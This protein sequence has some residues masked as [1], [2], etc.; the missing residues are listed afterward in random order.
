METTRIILVRHGETD[1][2]ASGRIQGHSDTP[3]NARGRIQAQRVAQRLA[4]EPIRALYSSDLARAFETATIIGRTLGIPVAISPQLRERRYGAWEGLTPAEIEARY[5]EQYAA[6]RTRSPDFA[7]PQG[8]TRLQLLSRALTELQTIAHRHVGE[9]VVVVTHGGLCYV[10]IN[11][12][13]GDVDG[14]R[15]E[16]TFGNASLH[17]LEM[18]GNRWSVIAINE[19]AHLQVAERCGQST[20]LPRST[21]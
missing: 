8:E 10:L 20:L 6:W 5:P 3:L 16:F 12:L 7:P 21:R 15:R 17:T 9:R 18:M 14:D 19:T 13:L 4:G 1:W 11:H 2:N